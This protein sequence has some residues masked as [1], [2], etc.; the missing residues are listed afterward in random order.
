MTSGVV[1]GNTCIFEGLYSLE[2]GVAQC[3]CRG[4]SPAILAYLGRPLWQQNKIRLVSYF[5]IHGYQ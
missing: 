3:D 1:V 5:Q 4:W 2:D